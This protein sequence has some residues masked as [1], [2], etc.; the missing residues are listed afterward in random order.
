MLWHSLSVGLELV[1]YPVGFPQHESDLS[2]AKILQPPQK[3][4]AASI[5][6]SPVEHPSEPYPAAP[7][8]L[9][10]LLSAAIVT[11]AFPWHVI[12]LKDPEGAENEFPPQHYA[13]LSDLILQQKLSP[14]HN[15][16][17]FA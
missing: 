12:P 8:Q 3:D 14:Q 13:P 5:T 6:M 4:E 10:S 7:K 11:P 16:P 9:E 17:M 1:P 15:G 2:E